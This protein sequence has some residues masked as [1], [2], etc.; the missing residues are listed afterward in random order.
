MLKTPS[1]K[2]KNVSVF[3]FDCCLMYRI[4]FIGNFHYQ[5]CLDSFIEYNSHSNLIMVYAIPE[6]YYPFF[7]ISGC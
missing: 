6:K 7:T 5:F 2:S 1:L 4:F 3:S